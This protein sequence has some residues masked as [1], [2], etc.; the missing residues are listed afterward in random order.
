MADRQG[1]IQ[2]DDSLTDNDSSYGGSDAASETTSL[3]SNVATYVYENGRRHHSYRAGSY[4][5]P[6]D[7]KAQDNLDLFHH[8]FTLSLDGRLF[9]APVCPEPQ[10]VLDLVGTGTGIWTT[11]FADD[12]PFA[13][14]VA[15]DLSPIQP[16]MVPPNLEFQIDD[17]TAPWTFTPQSFDFIHARSIYGCVAGYGALYAEDSKDLMEQAGF[18]NVTYRTFKW[19]IGPWPKDPKLKEI[20]AYN[21][22]DWEEGIERWAMYL[23]TKCLGWRA[24]EIQVLIAGIKS[25]LH[26]KGIHGYQEM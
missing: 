11:D 5:C 10:R 20:G 16:P 12:F 13:S 1:V 3:R 19:P 22:L 25:E 9:L 4:W 17:F 21:R 23:F 15:I 18:A 26:D 24:E 14:V 8:I 7:E 6:N 2:V